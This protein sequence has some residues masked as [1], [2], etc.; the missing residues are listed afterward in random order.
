[1]KASIGDSRTQVSKTFRPCYLVKLPPSVF[2]KAS[3]P[4]SAALAVDDSFATSVH[5]LSLFGSGLVSA[6]FEDSPPKCRCDTGENCHV[7]RSRG[8]GPWLPTE[9]KLLNLLGS[10]VPPRLMVIPI[11]CH[12]SIPVVE[13]RREEC[14]LRAIKVR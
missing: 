7:S 6:T 9:W 1:M 4:V 3:I 14:E 11:Y 5:A 8:L 10:K 13:S 2:L 12:R